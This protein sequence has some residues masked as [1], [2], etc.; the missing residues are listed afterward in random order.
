ML[1]TSIFSFSHNVFYSIKYRIFFLLLFNLSAAN[2]LNLVSSKTLS[3]GNGLSQARCWKKA[4]RL[5]WTVQIK[6]WPQV[7]TVWSLI[8]TLNLVEIKIDSKRQLN[9]V[10]NDKIL[11]LYKLKAFADNYLNVN[12][13]LKFAL[14]SLENIVGK[15]ENA[16][17]QH[18]LLFPQCFQKAFSLGSLNSGLCG[19]ELNLVQMM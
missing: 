18:F 17:Y 7:F 11:D 3:F 16:G 8:Y 14:R 1:V 13:K 12:Q 2:A 9:S 10:P 15:G 5:L 19:K 4:K 6:I